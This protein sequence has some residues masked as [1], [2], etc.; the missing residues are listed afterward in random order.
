MTHY[1]H[2]HHWIIIVITESS[3]ESSYRILALNFD[4]SNGALSSRLSW[5]STWTSILCSLID[6]V[7][8]STPMLSSYLPL[9]IKKKN[10]QGWY[11]SLTAEL[12]S[13]SFSK[14]H[15]EKWD[16]KTN[17]DLHTGIIQLQNTGKSE[18]TFRQKSE[19]YI[20]KVNIRTY[21]SLDEVSIKK[22]WHTRSLQK[23][24]WRHWKTQWRNDIF[25]HCGLITYMAIHI[26]SWI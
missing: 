17:W 21:I 14:Q 5:K 6:V 9:M 7:N 10:K 19:G 11:L 15:L 20:Q 1:H 26:E 25:Q 12:E 8:L 2:H 24:L 16:K 23:F 22:K 13:T 4:C 3:S 18:H